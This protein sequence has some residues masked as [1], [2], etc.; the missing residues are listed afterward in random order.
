[1]L[2]DDVEFYWLGQGDLLSECQDKTKN[3]NRIH[4]LGHIENVEYYYKDAYLY[5]QPSI[6]E[7][8]GMSVIDAMYFSIPCI[9]SDA[10]G[11]PETIEESISGFI[12]SSNN[13]NNYIE[14]IL[15]L[16]NDQSK[17]VLLGKK[18]NLRAN[19]IFHPSSQKRL[20]LN[21]YKKVTNNILNF[22]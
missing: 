5:L 3:N 2:N 19:Q 13:V 21:L 7:S 1:L 9:V 11:L 6:K 15:L 10:E 8:L 14:K 20:I 4:F 12:V 17:R 22:Y 16:L 18:A